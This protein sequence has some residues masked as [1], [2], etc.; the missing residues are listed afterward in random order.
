M[1]LFKI[2]NVRMRIEQA[3]IDGDGVIGEME[4]IST[5]KDFGKY[6]ITDTTELGEALAHVSKD[7]DEPSGFSSVDFIASINSY[8]HICLVVL[9]MCSDMHLLGGKT[10]NLV[11]NILRKTVS[12][13]ARGR[14]DAVKIASGKAEL[15]ARKTGLQNVTGNQMKQ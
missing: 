3:D 7:I 14:N 15:D 9:N 1:S 4:S 12:I 2:D 6:A 5:H 8:Q 11:R 10:K 13:D